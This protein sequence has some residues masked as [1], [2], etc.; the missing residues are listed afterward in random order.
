MHNWE[1]PNGGIGVSLELAPSPHLAFAVQSYL[2]VISLTRSLST[3]PFPIPPYLLLAPAQAPKIPFETH[4]EIHRHLSTSLSRAAIIS[5][6]QPNALPHTLRILRTYHAYS[7]AWPATFRSRQRQR[8]L[9]LYLRAL[10]AAY[11][12]AGIA[13]DNPYLL[14][15]GVSTLPARVTWRKEVVEA[16]RIGRTLLTAT[17]TFPRAGTVNLPVTT[18]TEVCVALTDRCPLLSRE[19]ISVLWWAQTLT[20]QSQPIFRHITR[21]LTAVGDSADARRTFE[22]YV[23][24]V[25]KSRQTQQPD[26]SLQLKRRPTE[27]VPAGPVDIKRQ[28][29]EAEDRH[30]S[31]AEGRKSQTSEAEGDTDEEFIEALL[32][33]TRLLVR[34]LQEPEDAWDYVCLAGDVAINGDRRGRSVTRGL[35]ARMEECKGVTRMSMAMLR[36]SRRKTQRRR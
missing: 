30:G 10:L 9:Q 6:R 23:Q 16:I 20:F 34:D 8:M 7:T 26:V 35:R 12:P 22:L 32:A 5:A 19:V 27:D 3:F 36:K 15:E 25:L 18:F 29:E 24:L 2:S 17:T 21:L 31:Q 13:S 28:A 11:P 4:R 14:D 1:E 33:G